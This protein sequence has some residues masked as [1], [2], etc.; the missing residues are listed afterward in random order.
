VTNQPSQTRARMKSHRAAAVPG[1]HVSLHPRSRQAREGGDLWADCA[2]EVG[3]D[4]IAPGR[5]RNVIALFSYFQ[6]CFILN[7]L[8]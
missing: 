7:S 5:P 2:V 1:P 4:Q 8:Y 6:F 3:V